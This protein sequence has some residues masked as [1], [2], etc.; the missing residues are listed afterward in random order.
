MPYQAE[1]KKVIN[2]D[3]LLWPKPGLSGEEQAALD[4]EIRSVLGDS[5][6]VRSVVVRKSEGIRFW[7][8]AIT[9]EQAEQIDNLSRVGLYKKE[10]LPLE[11]LNEL[12][13]TYCREGSLLYYEKSYP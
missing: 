4:D 7:V 9:P 2:P 12:P 10:S 6:G 3:Y 1:P 8:A 13:D 11:T 5:T